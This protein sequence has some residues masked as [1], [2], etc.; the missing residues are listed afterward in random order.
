LF[1]GQWKD[2]ELIYLLVPYTSENLPE[3]PVLD[4]SEAQKYFTLSAEYSTVFLQSSGNNLTIDAKCLNH[5]VL[6]INEFT[7]IPK[8][9]CVFVYSDSFFTE[10]DY[11]LADDLYET[12]TLAVNHLRQVL[13][14]IHSGKISV[15]WKNDFIPERWV[16]IPVPTSINLKKFRGLLNL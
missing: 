14:A 11:D 10:E 13:T 9:F 2:F 4:I 6:W 3:R 16:S 15:K 12:F 1:G 8:N 7:V 5:R